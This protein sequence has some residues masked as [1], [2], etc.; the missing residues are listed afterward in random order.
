MTL[1]RVWAMGL[2][3]LA[4][5]VAV[6][7]SLLPA[8]REKQDQLYERAASAANWTLTFCDRNAETCAKAVT[9]WEEFSKK[10]EFGAKLALDVMRDQAASGDDDK[11]APANYETAVPRTPTLS[12]GTLT[13]DDVKPAWRGKT[14]NKAGI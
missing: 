4:I 3:R 2:F 10:A 7:V 12:P 1:S 13:P 5:V 8:E 6:G 11:A 9:F 14:A